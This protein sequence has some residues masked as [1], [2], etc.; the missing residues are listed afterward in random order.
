LQRGSCSKALNATRGTCPCCWQFAAICCPWWWPCAGW[1]VVGDPRT[2]AASVRWRAHDDEPPFC[3]SWSGIPNRGVAALAPTLVLALA[4]RISM[5]ARRSCS[6]IG[7][8]VVSALPIH[9]VASIQEW[10]GSRP[11]SC[12]AHTN[13]QVRQPTRRAREPDRLV[14]V[15]R[16]I[17]VGFL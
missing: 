10:L 3:Q 11:T 5:A 8:P 7:G 17:R 13:N 1:V 2:G 4:L 12:G 9:C 14:R 16:G 15:F 6:I